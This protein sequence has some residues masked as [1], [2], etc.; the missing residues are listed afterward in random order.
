MCYISIAIKLAPTT[1]HKESFIVKKLEKWEIFNFADFLL[2]THI[3][4]FY[5]STIE[6]GIYIAIDICTCILVL[7]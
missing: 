3:F 4:Q 1:A 6:T 5:F 7:C 2:K